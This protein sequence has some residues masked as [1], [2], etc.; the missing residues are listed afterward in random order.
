MK[1]VLFDQIGVLV[2]N[3]QCL[4]VKRGISERLY[5]ATLDFVLACISYTVFMLAISGILKFIVLGQPGGVSFSVFGVFLVSRFHFKSQD[6][7]PCGRGGSLFEVIQTFPFWYYFVC[8][9]LHRYRFYENGVFTKK[10]RISPKVLD[11]PTNRS[12]IAIFFLW[13]YI[14][15]SQ[16]AR[17]KLGFFSPIIT[18]LNASL[19]ERRFF[20]PPSILQTK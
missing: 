4:G 2:S 6:A 9:T 12:I 5:F 11:K 15:H 20:V 8:V 10:Q 17:R 7:P 3:F 18:P 13:Q 14:I 19:I 1:F 16:M